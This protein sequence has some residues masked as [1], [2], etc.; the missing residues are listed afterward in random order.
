MHGFAAFRID[1]QLGE[2]AAKREVGGSALNS[3]GITLLIMELCY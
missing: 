2:D 1:A 3:Y